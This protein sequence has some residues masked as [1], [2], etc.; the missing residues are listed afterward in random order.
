MDKPCRSSPSRRGTWGT[1]RSASSGRSSSTRSRPATARRWRARPVI[2]RRREAAI[3]ARSSRRHAIRERTASLGLG[4]R[5]RVALARALRDR[6]R[7]RR[8]WPVLS[9]AGRVRKE[10]ARRGRCRVGPIDHLGRA[11]VAGVSRRFRPAGSAGLRRDP[12]NPGGR[13]PRL[14][15][16][17]MRRAHVECRRREARERGAAAPR[18]RTHAGHPRR[19]RFGLGLSGALC[20]RVRRRGDHPRADRDGHRRL[21]ALARPRP[22]AL[23]RVARRERV[24]AQPGAGQRPR[25]PRLPLLRL[26]PPAT[27]LHRPRLP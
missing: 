3:P 8:R 24:G 22:D 23:R 5:P 6:L 20:R 18:G 9:R 17:G 12:R 2:G 13:G 4:R 25:R 26:L 15:R 7:V 21:R 16:D 27:A 14:A 10:S 11:R 1:R 19:A